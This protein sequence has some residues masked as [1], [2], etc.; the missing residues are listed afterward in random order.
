MFTFNQ[1]FLGKKKL[2][3]WLGW[4]RSSPSTREAYVEGLDKE[5]VGG[6]REVPEVAGTNVEVGCFARLSCGGADSLRE[7]VAQQTAEESQNLHRGRAS[8]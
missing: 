4:Q 2:A 5:E 8:D 7:A 3:D 1:L 6:G